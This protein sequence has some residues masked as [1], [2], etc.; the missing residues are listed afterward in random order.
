MKSVPL[1]PENAPFS[2]EQRA[3][4]NGFLAGVLNRGAVPTGTAPAESKRPLLIA[5]GSQSGNAE[6]L[7]KRLAREAAG[8]GFAARAAGLDSLQPADLIKEQNL[9]LITS[10]WGEGD[11]PDNAISFWDSINQ[12]GSSPKLDGVQYSVLALGDKNYGETYCLAGRKLDARLAEL[13]AKR[14]ADRVDC[15]VDFDDLAKQWSAAAF[16]AL[17]GGNATAIVT[18]VPEA[19]VELEEETGYTKKNPFAARLIANTSLNARGSSKDTRHIGF[20]LAGS[21]LTYEVGDALGVFVQNCTE[22]VDAVIAAHAFDPQADVPLPDGGSAPL[23]EALIKH[24]EVRSLYGKAAA[25]GIPLTAFM[26]NLR[27]LQPRLYSIASSVKAHADEVHLCI[28]AVRYNADGVPHKGVASTFLADRLPLGETTGIYFHAANHFRLPADL[29]KPVIMVGPGTGIAP[30]RAFLEEREATQAPGKNWLFFGDQKRVSDFLYHD[31]IIEW[32]QKGH[33]TRLDTA[34][35]RDQEEKIYVQTRMLQAASELWQW[36][37][38]GAHFY[39]CGDAKRMAKDVD[40][41][42]HTIIQTAGG[43]SADEAAAYVSQMK[44]EKRYARD[45]Y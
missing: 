9:L 25:P 22:V 33:L 21:G 11:M 13:G 40:D 15:D 37:E 17:S 44:K 4:L 32:V 35:S 30:F 24:Y 5:F 42:L 23:R 36:L 2:V 28:A 27:K 38:E 16:T 26:E 45:V 3:W 34:F 12:N 6:S 10:T 29:T 41:A 43:K 31:Q 18:A 20:S 19:A 7:A 1:I 39:V 8:R 14:I